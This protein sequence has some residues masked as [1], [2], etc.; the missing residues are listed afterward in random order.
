[1]EMQKI[2]YVKDGLKISGVGKYFRIVGGANYMDNE[3]YGS[4]PC[5]LRKIDGDDVIIKLTKKEVPVFEEW[6]ESMSPSKN[7]SVEASAA[8]NISSKYI[9]LHSVAVAQN[10]NHGKSW[11]AT[12]DNI[13]RNSLHPS[14]EGELI[15]YVYPQ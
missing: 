7:T 14:W 2:S 5:S 3:K 9:E 6:V 13:D 12:L 11:R 8:K 1:M 10:L 4:W 15:C